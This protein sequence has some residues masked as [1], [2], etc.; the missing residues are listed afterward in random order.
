MSPVSVRKM[1]H[2]LRGSF[3]PDAKK[4][5]RKSGGAIDRSGTKKKLGRKFVSVC[6][7]EEGEV[8]GGAIGNGGG[9]GLDVE[10]ERACA[11]TRRR[12]MHGASW[13]RGNENTTD[14]KRLEMYPI[15]E[16]GLE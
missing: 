14:D 16:N 1:C 2:Q 6:V 5:G 8:G 15:L 12:G 11:R 9:G 4:S 7:Y 13:R 10:T 3:S